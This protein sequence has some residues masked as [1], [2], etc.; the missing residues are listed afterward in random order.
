MSE[1]VITTEKD[2]KKLANKKRRAIY[3][4]V[5]PYANDLFEGNLTAASKERMLASIHIS[6]LGLTK[7]GKARPIE[8]LKRFMIISSQFGVN[9]FKN[10]I[11]ATY[12]WNK[13]TGREE[14]TP[15]I[16]IHG[17][18]KLARRGG[19]YS[20]TGTAAISKNAEGKLESVTV[21]VFGLV[22]GEIQEFTRYTAFYDE[23]VR[24]NKNGEPISNWAKMPIVMLTKCAEAN[25][26]RQ[27][28]DISG[29][30]I[31]EEISREDE[32]II[33]QTEEKI[34]E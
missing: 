31:E 6:I 29:I 24:T 19:I 18:R 7:T 14:L 2:A 33:N 32:Q 10:E 23:F 15:I 8:D 28:F 3:G 22:N 27:A 30:Y 21:P 20:H 26:I 13:S 17:L 11:Y 34:N 12:I 9:P 25:A 16:S 1:S 4:E 5:V